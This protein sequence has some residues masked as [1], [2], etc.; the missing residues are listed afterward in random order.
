MSVDQ[1]SV[2]ERLGEAETADVGRVFRECLRG[3]SREMLAEAMTLK[4]AL[5]R[6]IGGC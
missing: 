5:I 2:L 1:R 6:A 3:V 4:P